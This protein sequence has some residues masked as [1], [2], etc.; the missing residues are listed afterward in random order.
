M[1]ERRNRLVRSSSA[2]NSGG[3]RA[4]ASAPVAKDVAKRSL[5]PS[6]QPTVDDQRSQKKKDKDGDESEE[7]DHVRS[8]DRF[9]YS[10]DFIGSP[11]DHGQVRR[12][13]GGGVRADPL[14]F[15]MR[16]I[17]HVRRSAPGRH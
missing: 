9:A 7:F 5:V 6:N 10:W 2:A 11:V 17:D 3:R 15:D 16:R 4:G 1:T 8:I 12:A 14:P 13:E